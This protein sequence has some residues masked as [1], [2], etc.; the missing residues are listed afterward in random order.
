M[1]ARQKGFEK[2]RTKVTYD[3]LLRKLGYAVH[4]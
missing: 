2:L 4:S 3:D 1:Y